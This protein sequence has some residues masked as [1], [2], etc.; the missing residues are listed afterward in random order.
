[1][2]KMRKLERSVAVQPQLGKLQSR[3]QTLQ[4]DYNSLLT[5]RKTREVLLGKLQDEAKGLGLA[6][7]EDNEAISTYQTL[8]VRYQQLLRELEAEEHTS[9]CL[10]AMRYDRTRALAECDLPLARLRAQLA[11]TTILRTCA[12]GDLQRW[13]RSLKEAKERKQTLEAVT[14]RQNNSRSRLKGEELDNARKRKEFELVTDLY[15]E[16]SA[17]S[18]QVAQKEDTVA[19]LQHGHQEMTALEEIAEEF[20]QH[21][22]YIRRQERHLA[23]LRRVF[24]MERAAE[25]EKYWEYL[26]HTE[27]T[28]QEFTQQLCENTA[29]ARALLSS[30]NQELDLARSEDRPDPPKRIDLEQ[31]LRDKETLLEAVIAKA[32]RRE[33]EVVQTCEIVTRLLRQTTNQPMEVTALGPADLAA[34]INRLEKQ[35]VT[36]LC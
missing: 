3:L 10:E 31:Q 2:G 13:T 32:E 28:L 15:R 14:E 19:L 35:L 23:K 33:T 11:K 6:A 12:E 16:Q 5:A 22:A 7:Q 25:A 27:A 30:L 36:Y 29:A 8:Q 20:T 1:M 18:Q 21:E 4:K 34:A 24:P 17:I 9:R 26:Q